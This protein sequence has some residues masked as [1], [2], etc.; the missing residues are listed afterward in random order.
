M[1]DYVL[2]ADLAGLIPASFI[3]QALDDNEDGESDAAAWAAVLAQVHQAIDGTLGMRFPVPFAAPLPAKVSEAAGIFACELLYMRRGKSGEQN[4]WTARADAMRRTLERI[5]EGK[6]P[7]TPETQRATPP[8][9]IVAEP[10][11]TTSA[12]GYTMA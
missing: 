10:A 3:V 11:K 8:I 7:L 12:A 1:P 4:P 5:A 9:S 6:L 2:I